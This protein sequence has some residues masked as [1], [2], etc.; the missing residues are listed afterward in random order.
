MLVTGGSS[1]VGTATARLFAQRGDRVW[2]T[3]HSGR[4]RAESLVAALQDVDVRAFAF[5]SGSQSSHQD[6]LDRLPG[7]VDVL[8]NNAAVGT[9]T[10]ESQ[11]TTTI[12][13]QDECYVRVNL[14]G[15]LWLTRAVLPGMVERGYGKILMVSSVGGGIAAFPGFRDADGMTKAA[16]AFLTR[17][18]AAELTHHPVEVFCICPGALDTPMFQQSTLDPLP[19]DETANLV[20]RLPRGRLIQP[21]EIAELLWWLSTPAATVLHG[22]VID[23]SMGLGA[24]PGLLTGHRATGEKSFVWAAQT[25]P[26]VVA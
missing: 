15:P 10:V 18:L 14:L 3:Y 26:A 1:G 8:V 9:K 5:D 21:T 17:K 25:C 20:R 22:A 12:Q 16:L 19:E 2:F 24:H 6:L 13:G 23:A 11:G 7:P 4:Q